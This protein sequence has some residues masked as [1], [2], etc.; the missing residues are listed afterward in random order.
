MKKVKSSSSTEKTEKA[1]TT[2]KL[3]LKKIGIFIIILLVCLSLIPW[4]VSS[5]F[6]SSNTADN[7]WVVVG[8]K[9]TID[10]V[11]LGEYSAFVQKNYYYIQQQPYMLMQYLNNLISQQ[12]N[13]LL[14]ANEAEAIGLA[15]DRDL[16]LDL[17]SEIPVF[18]NP[19]GT[20]NADEF[21]TKVSG[22]FGSEEAFMENITNNILR[23][24]LLEPMIPLV[25]QPFFV[26]YIDL[27]A[28]SQERTVKYIDVTSLISKASI[29]TPTTEDL[30]KLR[31]ENKSLFTTLES[32]N[33]SFLVVDVNKLINSIKITDSE[34][35]EHYERTKGNYLNPETRTI[36]QITFETKEEAEKAFNE[37][38]ANK[39][40]AK[41]FSTIDNITFNSLPEDFSKEIFNAKVN[42]LNKP[43]QSPV[44]WHI[45]KV[46]KID[47][48]KT[49]PFTEVK[50]LVKEDLLNSKRSSVL[51]EKRNEIINLVNE[52]LSLKEIAQKSGATY[53]EFKGLNESNLYDK[54]I[55][56]E[57]YSHIST[58]G[59]S[60]NSGLVDDSNGNFF[61]VHIDKVIPATLKT[62]AESKSEL[63]AL[64]QNAKI[65]EKSIELENKIIADISAG[66][67]IANLG[68]P[69]K[70]FSGTMGVK[71]IPFSA[72]TAELIFAST[73]NIPIAGTL[74]NQNRIV[75][76]V[77]SITN[78]DTKYAD[79]KGVRNQDV[80]N[81]THYVSPS[82]TQSY[83][84]RYVKILSK[85][86]DIKVNEEAIKNRL[87]PPQ[88]E[89]PTE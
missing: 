40:I 58:L 36:S 50:N 71:N 79:N 2:K 13:T 67:N 10:N 69:V 53:Q 63:L 83:F 70:K 56:E 66:K 23:D 42:E 21:R 54:K 28:L 84:E 26:S 41:E 20:F 6:L 15:V 27:L 18:K 31:D 16:L 29:P 47:S 11:I 7:K 55:S 9:Y 38:K 62:V 51:E 5:K 68:H 78:K 3:S 37:L 75:A 61:I 25:N 49:K 88:R 14:F 45:F 39:K 57:T 77:E 4:V 46:V 48:A 1:T 65:Q 44:G 87:A 35:K 72:D 73:K 59:E 24:Q 81:F 82:Y 76:V 60:Q 80:V 85:K 64:W 74:L 12:I 86:F 33:G 43:V 22:I 32:R 8:K 89:T 34:L 30:E 52:N 19:D 17:I